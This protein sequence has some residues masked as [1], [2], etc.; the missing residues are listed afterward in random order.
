MFVPRKSFI[1]LTKQQRQDEL[2]KFFEFTCE[3]VACV[4]DYSMAKNL[5]KIDKTFK[6]PKF[7]KFSSNKN[8]VLELQKCLKFLN[9]FNDCHPSFETA[10]V[11]LRT[12]ELIKKVCERISFPFENIE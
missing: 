6:L 12:K 9:D 10:A 4:N 7:G 11:M 2:L 8:L 3:C 5:N 1:S